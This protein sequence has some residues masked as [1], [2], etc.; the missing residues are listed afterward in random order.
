MSILRLCIALGST[1]VAE[2][3][4]VKR[5]PCQA[6]CTGLREVGFREGTWSD[7]TWNDW[8]W[9]APDRWS[10]SSSSAPQ[11]GTVLV[12]EAQLGTALSIGRT[13]EWNSPVDTTSNGPRQYGDGRGEVIT[14]FDGT[15]FRQYERPV[16]LS[17]SNTRVAPERRA[18]ELLE[19]LLA[20]SLSHSLALSLSLSFRPP[21]PY[22]T[23]SLLPS[24][25]HPLS[26][27]RCFFL[28]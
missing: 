10:S 13:R 17:V 15:D 21:S 26:L 19:R 12:D 9:R 5:R 8:R 1:L 20:L 25:H 14:A 3:L 24:P 16:R 18:G 22:T 27:Q 7:G 11:A 4:F 28:F 2:Y 23:P 6:A